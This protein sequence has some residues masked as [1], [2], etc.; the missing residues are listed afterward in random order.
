ML[1]TENLLRAILVVQTAEPH[2]RAVREPPVQVLLVEVELCL[3]I[4][5]PQHFGPGVRDYGTLHV[6]LRFRLSHLKGS[7]I[8]D[9][10][11]KMLRL[12]YPE[13]KFDLDKQDLNGRVSHGSVVW[14][15]G[16]GD[17]DRTEKILGPE[18]GT[19]FLNEC[20]Q[21]PFASRN[22]AV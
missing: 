4:A 15:G 10:W 9:T 1:L 7:V 12:C 14:F 5:K 21:I 17:K 3:G 13:A 2:L 20:S 18:D 11:P 16:L 19:I 6:V 8:A 22:I